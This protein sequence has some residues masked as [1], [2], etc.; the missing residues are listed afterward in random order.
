ML[1]QIREQTIAP[2]ACIIVVSHKR[3]SY[4]EFPLLFHATQV[5]RIYQKLFHRHPSNPLS[6]CRFWSDINKEN[7]IWIFGT[8]LKTALEEIYH[9]LCFEVKTHVLKIIFY[10]HQKHA[11]FMARED[12]LLGIISL[13]W[14]HGVALKQEINLIYELKFPSFMC[15]FKLM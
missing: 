1:K 3:S 10:Y 7:W 4:I 12:L 14:M 13:H 11:Q 15:S 5:R 6:C 2:H 9:C 8:L